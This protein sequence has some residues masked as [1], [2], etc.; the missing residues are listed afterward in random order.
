MKPAD[1]LND[2]EY[3][4][5]LGTISDARIAAQYGISEG[6]V[7]KHRQRLNISASHKFVPPITPEMW[8]KMDRMLREGTWTYA[9]IAKGCHVHYCTVKDRA[10]AIGIDRSDV[11]KQVAPL[12]RRML[13]TRR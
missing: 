10:H 11:A 7:Y 9:Q 1:L 6:A 12:S 5:L 13:W 4:A 3:V 2:P 8:A